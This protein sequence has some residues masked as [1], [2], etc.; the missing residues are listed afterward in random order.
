[1][2]AAGGV[3]GCGSSTRATQPSPTARPIATASP[4]ASAS[5]A[6]AQIPDAHQLTFQQSDI[7]TGFAPHPR[8]ILTIDAT[9]VV[10]EKLLSDGS[11]LAANGFRSGA[12]YGWE[13]PSDHT[14]AAESVV[15]VFDS[16]E[17]A[18]AVFNAMVDTVKTYMQE[19]A[20]SATFGDSEFGFHQGDLNLALVQQGSIDFLVQ[21][22]PASPQNG[23]S[24]ALTLDRRLQQYGGSQ[25]TG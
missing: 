8:A 22:S 19:N 2:L 24:L 15:M 23:V 21:T 25:F 14:M 3:V 4:S 11:L 5:P 16:F 20:D 1:M 17:Q 7:P 10:S 9:T 12:E 18:R 6:T 13:R